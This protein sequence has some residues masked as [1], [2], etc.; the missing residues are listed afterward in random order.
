MKNNVNVVN[1]AGKEVDV[2]VN[3]DGNDIPDYH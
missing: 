3:K 2:V 1:N